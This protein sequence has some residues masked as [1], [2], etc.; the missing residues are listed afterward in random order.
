[1]PLKICRI[2]T[3]KKVI[4]IS[5]ILFLLGTVLYQTYNLYWKPDNFRRQIYLIPGNAMYIIETE[6]P[7]GNWKTF[8]GS[9]PWQYLR[10]QEKMKTIGEKADKL[11][12][13][14]QQNKMLMNL[15][16]KRNLMISAHTTN[17]FDYDF[18]FV[19]DMQK[20]SKVETLK[21]QLEKLFKSMDYKVTTR[22]FKD[23]KIIELFDPVDRSILYTVF[24]DNHLICSYTGLLVE[25]S[26]REKDNPII[27]RDF[28]FHEVEQ[29]MK[30]SELCRIYI[31]YNYFNNYLISLLGMSE[32][33][34]K[35]VC[36][37]MEY[38]GLQMNVTD[39]KLS[40]KGY[41]NIKDSIDSYLSA[42]LQS[43]S[44]K[45]TAQHILSNRTA[46]F[47]TMNFDNANMFMNNVESALKNDV[48]AYKSFKS[49]RDRIE[50]SLG[51]DIH[52]NFLSWMDGEVV[53]AQ[54][55]PGPLGRQNEFVAVVK[56]KHKNDAI[57]NLDIIEE[58]IRKKTPVRF[59]TIDYA[60]YGIHYLE[61]N[62]FFRLLFGKMFEKLNKPYYTIIDD[63]VVFSN[64]AATLLSMVE[65][66]RLGQ[67]LENEEEFTRFMKEFNNK[68]SIF[69]YIN[70]IKSFSLWKEFVSAPTWENMQDN[71]DFVL[72]F[73]QTGFQL[74]SDKIIF[75]T[76]IVA[77]FLVPEIE[78]ISTNDV[79]EEKTDF[80]SDENSLSDLQLFYIE[81]MSG[82]IY[83]EFYED[84]A[85]R[86]RTEMKGG[87]RN[88][89]Y[90]EFYP[91][92]KLKTYG[93]FKNNKRS[94]EWLY[95]DDNEKLLRKEKWKN[96]I[97]KI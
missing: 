7:V 25:K 47:V 23:C 40:F 58:R 92:G 82:N 74:T 36:E 43:G 97:L 80:P 17:R 96:G 68:S 90:K 71:Q 8:S 53:F 33:N 63:Y 46:F 56:M 50:N 94:G 45:I 4:I 61:M 79:A 15:L 42:L 62:G 84:G 87:L 1:M 91:D 18:L 55:T 81:K 76:R 24:I 13:I 31:N 12:S 59:K 16:G 75:D 6:L 51:I 52:K 27:G 26:I 32:P 19:I 83:T 78:D 86:S 77:E 48:N 70:T 20:A 44:S 69:V 28:Y 34:V 38:T 88:G 57:A 65:D 49:N 64:S 30:G 37:S 35:D 60:G 93:K 66:Y 67:T 14:L 11:D 10:R 89:K 54:N 29:K 72:C 39:A 3:R 2:N 9:A 21:E 85:I 5:I 41:T 22:Q 73:P 95:Y